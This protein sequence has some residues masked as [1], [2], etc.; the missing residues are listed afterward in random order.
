MKSDHCYGRQGHKVGSI[1][2]AVIFP[3]VLRDGLGTSIN[4]PPHLIQCADVISVALNTWFI[5]LFLIGCA[6]GCANVVRAIFNVAPLMRLIKVAII[7]KLKRCSS[8]F[9][10]TFEFQSHPWT[11]LIVIVILDKCICSQLTNCIRLS[12]GSDSVIIALP[13][14]SIA[15]SIVDI[16]WGA[17]N[18]LTKSTGLAI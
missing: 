7:I 5:L 12:V 4:I 15:I 9:T 6:P 2:S 13:E 11:T 1:T 8:I 16:S 18:S 10:T 17:A 14:G 3:V